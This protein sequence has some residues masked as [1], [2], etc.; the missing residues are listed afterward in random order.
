MELNIS[1]HHPRCCVQKMSLSAN[2]IER[3]PPISYSGLRTPNEFAS[4]PVAWPKVG[5]VQWTST[6]PHPVLIVPK[7]GWLNILKA[8]ARNCSLTRSLIGNSRRTAMSSCQAP[9]PRTKFRGTSPGPE[10]TETKASGLNARP[11][12]HGSVAPKS[13]AYTA[14]QC[15]P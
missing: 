5:L 8:S 1:C 9:K 10:L 13:A 14:L 4:V 6:L 15:A 2:C 12:G 7:L 11:P 3:G